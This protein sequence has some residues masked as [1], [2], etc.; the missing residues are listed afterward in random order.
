MTYENAY[1]LK[2][3]IN[4]HQR[5]NNFWQWTLNFLKNTFLENKTILKVCDFTA[6]VMYWP[7]GE[8]IYTNDSLRSIRT[9]LEEK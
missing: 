2:K 7:E 3:T 4:V 1:P 8:K 5:H 9:Q 6:F